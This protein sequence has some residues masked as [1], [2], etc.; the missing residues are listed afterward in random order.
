MA[1]AELTAGE[2]TEG[3]WRRGLCTRPSGGD[4]GEG[5]FPGKV[6]GVRQALLA[7][8]A[9]AGSPGDDATTR[10]L[11]QSPPSVPR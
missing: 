4:G 1:S 2:G 7:E 3:S 10:R 9:L 11:S 5:V 6:V 8:G